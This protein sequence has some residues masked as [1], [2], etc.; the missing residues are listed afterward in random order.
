M[1]IRDVL[2]G[3]CYNLA[4][5]ADGKSHACSNNSYEQCWIFGRIMLWSQ[6]ERTMI[7]DLKECKLNAS[8]I[9][10]QSSA[11]NSQCSNQQYNFWSAPNMYQKWCN[12]F[13]W[14]PASECSKCS[15][16][17]GNKC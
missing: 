3:K 11:D 9:S 2:A 17:L 16:E 5:D 1:K 4:V 10:K 6:E 13:V 12:H 8:I 7:I 15:A 14:L